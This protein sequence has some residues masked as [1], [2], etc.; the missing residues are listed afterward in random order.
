MNECPV[1]FVAEEVVAVV[2][3][4]EQ[5]PAVLVAA[6]D[7]GPAGVSGATYQH[8][9]PSPSDN[10]IINHNLGYRP[11]VAAYSV[12]GQIMLANIIHMSPNQARILFDGPV[13]GFA[14][15]S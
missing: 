9:Q 5:V 13:S 14:V 2:V 11:A 10:W 7:Q 6:G 3:E 15:C 4:A 1:A 12:G 8:N